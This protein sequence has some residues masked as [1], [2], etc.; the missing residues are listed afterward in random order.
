MIK[1]AIEDKSIHSKPF[2]KN[3][4]NIVDNFFTY[5]FALEVIL[6][7]LAY[8]FRKYF[9]DWWSWLDFTI[10]LVFSLIYYLYQIN[11]IVYFKVSLIG[12]VSS[13][14]GVADIPAFKVMRT[15]RALRPLRALSRFEGIRV[16][17]NALIGA[18]PSIFNVLLVCL[19]F[20]LVF[21]I[22]GVQLFAGKFYKCVY[23]NMTKVPF[24]E[25]KNINDCSR[26]NFS[27]T[28]SKINF[29]NTI[30]AYLALLQVATFKGWIEIMVDAADM[31]HDVKFSFFLIFFNQKLK[32]NQQPRREQSIY[33]LLYFVFFIVF[34]SFFTLNLFIGVII[35]NFNQQ[36]KKHGKFRIFI[37][38]FIFF[39]SNNRK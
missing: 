31:S 6:K 15:L 7:W 24:D 11:K 9:S 4:I 3:L 25:V 23:P 22:M 5:T 34:G 1:K 30:N 20:W 26:K 19:V 8:G 35:D 18:I 12:L 28:N 36:K 37:L 17:V 29:D 14:I 13:L 39:Y 27:W 10:V 2:L 32:I 38:N 16:V 21:S 33:M